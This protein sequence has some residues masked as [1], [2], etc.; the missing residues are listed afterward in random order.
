[1]IAR[2]ALL[3][4]TRDIINL[5]KQLNDQIDINWRENNHD[6]QRAITV[7]LAELLNHHGYKW[8]KKQKR[9]INQIHLEI[10]DIFHFMLCDI[11]T[12]DCLSEEHILG[13]LC[14]QRNSY[15][16]ENEVIQ[17]IDTTL[18]A[19]AQKK[20]SLFHLKDLMDAYFMDVDML[21]KLYLGKNTLNAFRQQNGYN[22]G[23]YKKVWNGLEDNQVLL[24]ILNNTELDKDFEQSVLGRL[25]FEY[26]L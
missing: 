19:A 7:E 11:L 8:W 25:S 18:T 16:N 14:M 24:N 20:F 4:T 15:T 5:Q 23:T 26:N 21:F 2:E 13:T 3:K 17:L 9:D 1:M 12:D 6:Y 10:V 22:N